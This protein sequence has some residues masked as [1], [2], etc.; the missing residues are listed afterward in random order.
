MTS[1][2]TA[3]ANWLVTL[4]VVK[5]RIFKKITTTLYALILQ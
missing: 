5:P 2:K 1:L 3:I 4:R